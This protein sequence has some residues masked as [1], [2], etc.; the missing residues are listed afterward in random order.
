MAVKP[1]DPAPAFQR[2]NQRG[3]AVSLAALRGKVVV[4][5][6][7][8]KDDTPICTKEACAFRDAY[9]DFTRAGAT[10]IGVS[11][12][13]DASHR[14]FAENHRLP[15]ELIADEDG[16]L[17]R[18]FGVPKTLGLLK[19]R[20]TYVID[21]QGMVRHV[22]TAAFSA[23]RHVEEALKVVNSLAPR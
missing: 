19:G 8:P 17:A 4:L 7:Y 11:A 22:F 23:D 16:A 5:Y 3:E 20:T 2:P 6:F 9:E 1:G 21:A 10:V 18:A 14:R 15:F 13:S 12:D